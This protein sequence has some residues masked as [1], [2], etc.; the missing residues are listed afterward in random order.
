MTKKDYIKIA[1]V[2]TKVTH[3]TTN[4]FNLDDR[5]QEAKKSLMDSGIIYLFCE[6]LK[7]DNP[8]F[9]SM[10]FVKQIKKTI[11]VTFKK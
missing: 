8:K 10:K 5:D 2:L 3:H 7:K 4:Y 1:D 11:P 6:M 9:D